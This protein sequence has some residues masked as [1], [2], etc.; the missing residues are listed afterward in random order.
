MYVCIGFNS[1]FVVATICIY[2][3]CV[4]NY[5]LCV[6]QAMTEVRECMENPFKGDG[7]DNLRGRAFCYLLQFTSIMAYFNDLSVVIIITSN[8]TLSFYMILSNLFYI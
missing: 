6:V 2:I 5:Y 3:T 8:L 4:I 7:I 1:Y